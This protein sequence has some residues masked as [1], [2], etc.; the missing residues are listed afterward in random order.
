M[1]SRLVVFPGYSGLLVPTC[2]ALSCCSFLVQDLSWSHEMLSSESTAWLCVL[3]LRY[4]MVPTLRVFVCTR[5]S[6]CSSGEVLEGSVTWSHLRCY[7]RSLFALLV[8]LSFVA[9]G[10]LTARFGLT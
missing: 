2:L 7:F 10:S 8:S 5:C 4:L 3:Y 9:P 6:W 1:V